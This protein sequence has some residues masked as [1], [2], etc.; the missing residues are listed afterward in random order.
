VVLLVLLLL[1]PLLFC[2]RVSSAPGVSRRLLLVG[3]VHALLVRQP[4]LGQRA[5][6]S[7]V[8]QKWFNFSIL[9]KNLKLTRT[10][11][12]SAF[13]FA[14]IA[15]FSS[16]RCI[17]LVLPENLIGKTP[18]LF[19]DKTSVTGTEYGSGS[20]I[21]KKVLDPAPEAQNATFSNSH[22]LSLSY[23]LKL[24]YFEL[25]TKYR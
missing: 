16:S 21:P 9:P 25:L 2:Q 18:N 23:H 11:F 6:F 14:R 8:G 15:E 4:L 13:F 12:Q 19:E 7:A 10:I 22:P 3:V 20:N 5:V 17:S 1:F 24:R